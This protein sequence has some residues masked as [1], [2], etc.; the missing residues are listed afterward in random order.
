MD[1]NY[2]DKKNLLELAL[3]ILEGL[4]IFKEPLGL[5]LEGQSKITQRKTLM[6][7]TV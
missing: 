2:K 4:A 1:I 7:L 5:V 3:N 6:L